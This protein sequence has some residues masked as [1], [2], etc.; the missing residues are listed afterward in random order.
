MNGRRWTWALAAVVLLGLAVRFGYGFGR[1][2]HPQMVRNIR[3]D[4]EDYLHIAYTLAQTGRYARPGAL[5]V[6]RLLQ[7]KPAVLPVPDGRE[8]DA[9]RPPV[10]PW[11]LA[12]WLRWSG[13]D[14]RAVF[15]L[16]FLL[17]AA[18]LILF[19]RVASPWLQ[20][21]LALV[22]TLLL[23]LHPAWIYY[24]ATLLSEP[25]ILLVHLL[26]TLAVLRLAEGKA[27]GL[28]LPAAG[29]LGGLAM[30]THGYYLFF[31]PLLVA[32]LWLAK[33]LRTAQALA[34]L[35][36]FALTLAP[37]IL[38]NGRIYGTPLLST[39][40]GPS[41]SRGWNREFLAVYRN[42]T[43]EV[44]LDEQL[45]LDPALLER[46]DPAERSALYTSRAVQFIRRE[47]RMVPAI[48]GKKLVGA[49]SPFPDPP[50]PGLLESGRM[51]FQVVTLVPVLWVLF[52]GTG[53]LPW[54]VR[55]LAASYLAMGLI[56]FPALRYRFPLIWAEVLSLCL[57]A[58]A[59]LA[60]RRSP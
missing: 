44:D 47:W 52:R 31:P 53:P 21:P 1:V 39:A 45:D 23:A 5:D 18:T 14:L 3:G 34:L 16:R 54:V 13:Y 49:V 15:A 22:G 24:S 8:P 35:G 30:L 2:G 11:F 58:Q 36:L 41:L 57:F 20:P 38:R 42:G 56:C 9:W 43:A 26:F 4:A 19:F 33:R 17:D 27:P 25:L 51:L 55:A 48:L 59:L 6:K 37:W 10:W 46:L 12:R 29:A 28:W 32:C 50:R 7:A 40:S 60:W